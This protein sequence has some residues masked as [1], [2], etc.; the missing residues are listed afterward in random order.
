MSCTIIL[1]STTGIE[2]SWKASWQ[3]L[4]ATRPEQSFHSANLIFERDTLPTVFSF[5]PDRLHCY[6]VTT[7]GRVEVEAAPDFLV[8]ALEATTT[9]GSG[10]T[11]VT[12]LAPA[13]NGNLILADIFRQRMQDLEYIEKV[14]TLAEPLQPYDGQVWPST[15]GLLELVKGSA[16]AI[17]MRASSLPISDSDWIPETLTLLQNELYNRLPRPLAVPDLRRRTLAF[18]EGSGMLPDT[19]G[20]AT[21]FYSAARSLGVDVVVLGAPGHWIQG[22]EY[23]HWCKE[24][25]PIEFG[26]DAGFASR[27]VAALRQSSTPVEALLTTFDSYH[28]AVSQAAGELGLPHEPTGA[29]EIATDKFRLSA[30]EGRTCFRAT[31]I[32]NL[33]DTALTKAL[34][35]PVIVKPCRGWGSELV[36][37]AANSQQLITWANSINTASSHGTEFLIEPY[38]DGPEVDINFAMYGG[39]VLFWGQFSFVP[40]V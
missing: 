37:R 15:A 9:S 40:C 31:G 23:R 17:R 21:Q 4:P 20:C 36:F 22:P 29:Y 5:H 28:V 7:G 24:F 12:L 2:A 26:H 34:P 38:C 13:H 1:Q 39:E 3:V 11:A 14:V 27:I 18:L 30:F 10:K 8:D 33:I 25:I 6:L 35:W 19:G 16:G 32:P